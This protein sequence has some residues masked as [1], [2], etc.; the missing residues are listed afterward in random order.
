M[1][2]HVMPNLYQIAHM[3]I[4]FHQGQVIHF[5]TPYNLILGVNIICTWSFLM[6]V[7]LNPMLVVFTGSIKD[8][9]HIQLLNTAGRISLL[10]PSRAQQ[11]VITLFHFPWRAPNIARLTWANQAK[12][13]FSFLY[14]CKQGEQSFCAKPTSNHPYAY[15][16]PSRAGYLL[17]GA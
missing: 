16:L 10:L 15:Y 13:L 4:Y 12:F 11:R 6:F 2:N 17:I 1:S 8:K 7:A 5:F 14:N 9:P 3:L